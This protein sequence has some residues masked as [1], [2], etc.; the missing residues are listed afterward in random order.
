MK[1]RLALTAFLIFIAPPVLSQDAAQSLKA[2]Y[3]GKTLFLRY[4]LEQSTQKFDQQCQ[5][6]EHGA[7]GPWTF[8]G[9]ILVKKLSV[10]S[11]ELLLEGVR[12]GYRFGGDKPISVTSKQKMKLELAAGNTPDSLDQA[13]ACLGRMVTANQEDLWDSYPPMWRVYFARQKP[14]PITTRSTNDE[15]AQP[16]ANSRPQ[17]LSPGHMTVNRTIQP[18]ALYTP[19]P[20]YFEPARKMRISGTVVLNVAITESGTV[21]NVRLAQPFGMGLDEP[22]VDT[23]KTWRFEPGQRDGKAVSVPLKVEVIFNLY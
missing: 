14:A 19:E 5:L 21:E 17:A 10:K 9:G 3:E 6:T 12:V 23:V 11:G 20:Q 13:A 22:A 18:R 8:Y 16:M 4:S 2:R 7:D 15:A 1:L